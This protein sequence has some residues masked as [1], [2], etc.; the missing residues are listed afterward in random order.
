MALLNLFRDNALKNVKLWSYGLR[1][2]ANLSH[3]GK[4]RKII[5]ER[6]EL[7]DPRNT[8]VI[9]VGHKIIM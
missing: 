3:S 5:F 2:E 9:R 4:K 7:Y 6:K 1:Y 8:A